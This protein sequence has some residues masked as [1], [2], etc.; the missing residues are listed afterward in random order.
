[1]RCSCKLLGSAQQIRSFQKRTAA[2][3]F[4]ICI[5][6]LFLEMLLGGSKCLT[7][8]SSFDRSLTVVQQDW[9]RVHVSRRYEEGS[10]FFLS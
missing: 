9:A 7:L 5:L 10:F 1:M 8:F 4:S 2:M 6:I 3:I